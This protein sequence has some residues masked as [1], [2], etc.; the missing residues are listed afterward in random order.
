MQ[1]TKP[2]WNES[3]NVYRALSQKSSAVFQ[4][5]MAREGIYESQS[6]R[7]QHNSHCTTLQ[8][9]AKSMNPNQLRRN[10]MAAALHCNG[11]RNL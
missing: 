8:Q 9:T 7:V 4:N 5:D 3:Y 2:F 10:T 11:L 1:K 6:T